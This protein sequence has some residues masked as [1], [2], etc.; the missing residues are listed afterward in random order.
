MYM[1]GPLQN[2]MSAINKTLSIHSKPLNEW[3][4]ILP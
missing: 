2:E 3:I 4:F 1:I